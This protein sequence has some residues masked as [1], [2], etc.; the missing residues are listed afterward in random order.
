MQVL[1]FQ[2]LYGYNP[3]WI[4][5]IVSTDPKVQG[6]KERLKNIRRVCALMAQSWEKVTARQ[7]ANYNKRYNYRTFK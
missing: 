5:N 3:R 6:V 4:I 7:A 1:P 2:A